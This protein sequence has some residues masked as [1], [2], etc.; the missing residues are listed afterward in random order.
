MS[1]LERERLSWDPGPR[2]WPRTRIQVEQV[3]QVMLWR[4]AKRT[5]E[6]NW[7]TD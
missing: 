2:E 6:P 4:S 1:L 5:L 3:E 7:E